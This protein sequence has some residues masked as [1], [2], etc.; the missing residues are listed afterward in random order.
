MEM[1]LLNPTCSTHSFAC[2]TR[3]NPFTTA[4]MNVQTLNLVEPVI[5]GPF[6][7]FC[8]CHG[9]CAEAAAC[10]PG[11]A[12]EAGHGCTT[13]ST[14]FGCSWQGPA[15]CGAA[16]AHVRLAAT[17]MA[18]KCESPCRQ[19]R[20]PLSFVHAMMR[21]CVQVQELQEQLESKDK[22]A[23]AHALAAKQA[24]RKLEEVKSAAAKAVA[25]V[26]ARVADAV[27]AVEARC[28]QAE[29]ARVHLMLCVLH[30]PA[31]SCEQPRSR[32]QEHNAKTQEVCV[33]VPHN[34][35][36]VA[37]RSCAARQQALSLQVSGC[38]PARQYSRGEI[39]SGD[40]ARV[41]LSHTTCAFDLVVRC[42]LH[43]QHLRVC[44]LRTAAATSAEMLLSAATT[45]ALSAGNRL[46]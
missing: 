18:V 34:T 22:E 23:R 44:G 26:N 16:G 1:Q 7:P 38:P 15:A 42:R 5:C 36:V 28:K 31:G 43:I 20:R 12:A 2:S 19:L 4:T 11:A 37:S 30:E 17:L 33:C 8:R 9:C 35:C 41:A 21:V 13:A 3:L 29:D 45:Q 10:A 25:G 32:L 24:Q 14:G 27:A 6:R 39:C 46:C 40:L